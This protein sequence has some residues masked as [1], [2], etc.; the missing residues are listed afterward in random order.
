MGLVDQSKVQMTW[1]DRKTVGGISVYDVTPTLATTKNG[2]VTIGPKKGHAASLARFWKPTFNVSDGTKVE[3]F[4]PVGVLQVKKGDMWAI[5]RMPDGSVSPWH[6]VGKPED[7]DP[8]L[9]E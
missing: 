2:G 9:I 1:A 4:C 7:D 8:E 5:V 6:V 3:V